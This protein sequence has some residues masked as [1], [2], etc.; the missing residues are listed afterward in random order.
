[1][2][3]FLPRYYCRMIP[4][5]RSLLPRR[6]CRSTYLAPC[7]CSLRLSINSI[8][9]P[10]SIGFPWCCT[11]RTPCDTPHSMQVSCLRWRKGIGWQSWRNWAAWRLGLDSLAQLQLPRLLLLTSL[12]SGVTLTVPHRSWRSTSPAQLTMLGSE[13]SWSAHF[14]SLVHAKCLRHIARERFW[15][16][17][18]SSR[19]N[20]EACRAKFVFRSCQLRP[21]KRINSNFASRS[22]LEDQGMVAGRTQCREMS[23]L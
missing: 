15:I 5:N 17:L 16:S 8:P 3:T 22:T 23:R 20:R 12:S 10:L 9:V 19:R 21:R 4:C 11:F 1:M 7:N 18:T 6:L 14:R 2:Y 13:G